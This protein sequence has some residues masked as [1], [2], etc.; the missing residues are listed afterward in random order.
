MRALRRASRLTAFMLLVAM[1]ATLSAC[2]STTGDTT[3][4]ASSPSAPEKEAQ[5][6]TL[7]SQAFEN[8]GLI[9][10]EYAATGVAGGQ[11]ISIPYEW[12]GAPDGTKSFALVLVDLHPVAHS[13]VH[14]MVTGIAPEASSLARGASGSAMP[15]GA[16]EHPNTSGRSG[17]SGPQPPIGSGNH[18]YNATLYALDIT[19][20]NPAAGTLHEFVAAIDGHVLASADCS[21]LFG[22]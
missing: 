7:S 18:E 10:V 3:V 11:N 6:L 21:G 15:A 14:W 12:R 8:G 1:L 5:M 22:R 9:P 4:P 2:R 13:W 17:Y 16:V 19:S 20:P